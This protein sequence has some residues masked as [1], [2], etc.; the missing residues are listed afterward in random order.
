M[1]D[2]TPFVV[3]RTVRATRTRVWAAW[4]EAHRLEK[5]W[6][7]KGM[8]LGVLA[9][10]VRPGGLFHYSMKLP[11]GDMW[12]GRFDYE[13]VEAPGRLVYLSG[14]AD[15]AGERCRPPFADT[16]PLLVRNELQFEDLGGETR[17]TLRAV[18]VDG[19]AA[20]IAT[21]T[22]MF[23]SMQQGFGS[24]FDVLEEYLGGGD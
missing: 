15:A 20:A 9:L 10:D 5:W 1:S 17:L 24:T 16:F 7:P 21:F 14:F 6:G 22:G 19:D 3:S 18:P 13:A 12:Y 23:A 11:N 8:P 4:T 2:P